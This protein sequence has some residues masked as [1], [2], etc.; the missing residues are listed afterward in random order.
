MK[1]IHFNFNH[2]VK[3]RACLMPANC[4]QQKTLQFIVES[5][6]DDTLNVPIEKCEQGKW[7]LLLDWEHDGK[8]FTHRE[9]FTI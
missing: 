4:R 7:T 1:A 5:E 8:L 6:Q 9:Q 2:P 3:G